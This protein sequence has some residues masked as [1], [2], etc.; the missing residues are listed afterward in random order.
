LLSNA[1]QQSVD[2][3]PAVKQPVTASIYALDGMVRRASSLQLT[4]DAKVQEATP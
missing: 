2:L 3:T 4:A 1:S